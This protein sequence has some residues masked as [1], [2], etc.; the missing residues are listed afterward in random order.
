MPADARESRVEPPAA[1][2]QARGPGAA[3][4]LDRQQREAERRGA[5]AAHEQLEVREHLQRGRRHPLALHRLKEPQR[6]QALRAGRR[7]RRVDGL[8]APLAD[9]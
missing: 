8:G 4:P 9:A 1:A 6:L 7:G 5:V 2:A 3:P